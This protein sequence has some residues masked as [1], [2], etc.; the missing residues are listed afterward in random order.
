MEPAGHRRGMT[1]QLERPRRQLDKLQEGS[2]LNGYLPLNPMVVG[3]HGLS[4]WNLGAARQ[5]YG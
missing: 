3:G 5:K 1:H 2:D 4:L